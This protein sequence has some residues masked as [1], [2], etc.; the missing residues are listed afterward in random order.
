MP[1]LFTGHVQNAEEVLQSAIEYCEKYG[2]G[3]FSDI[4]NLF[5]APNVSFEFSLDLRRSFDS[6]VDYIYDPTGY[7]NGAPEDISGTI[8]DRQMEL[9][10]NLGLQFFLFRD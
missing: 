1:W 9:G 7:P 6:N 5:L 10:L 2:V 4:A 8:E 3:Q